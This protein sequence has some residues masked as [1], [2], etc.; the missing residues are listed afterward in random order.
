M[1]LKNWNTDAAI[2]FGTELG[3]SSEKI[4]AIYKE[5]DNEEKEFSYTTVN[6]L[7]GK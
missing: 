7:N 1:T 2:I 4:L 3:S 5:K 6:V